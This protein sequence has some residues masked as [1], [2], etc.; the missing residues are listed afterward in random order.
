[1]TDA[2]LL[3]FSYEPLGLVTIKRAVALLYAGKAEIV[4]G[5]D[6]ELHSGRNQRTGEVLAIALPSV[7]RLLYYVT[8]RKRGVSLTKKNVLLRDD[9]RCAYCNQQGGDDMTVDHV[10]P[11]SR[12]GRSVWTNLV[13]CC[14]PCNTRKNNRTP[15]EAGM[16]LRHRPYVPRRIPFV[17][18]RRHTVPTEWGKYLTLY[19]IGI[20]E[21]PIDAGTPAIQ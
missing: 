15:E 4:H 14:G 12:G 6:R 11:R 7:L 20:E 13:G 9:Y 3:N 8:R 16:Q 21:R 2:L 18:V 17:V 19:G 10:H 5:G 1:M